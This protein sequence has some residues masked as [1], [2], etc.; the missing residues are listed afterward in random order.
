MGIKVPP[1]WP[2][3]TGEHW[4]RVTLDYY[5]FDFPVWACTGLWRRRST[6][7]IPGWTLVFWI[8]HDYQ[9]STIPLDPEDPGLAQRLVEIVEAYSS[10][11]ACLLDL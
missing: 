1:D 9:C 10:E 3:L 5:W 4:Y 11:A 2:P 8:M 7:C 6:I